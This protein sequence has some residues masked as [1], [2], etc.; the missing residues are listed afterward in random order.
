MPPQR[1]GA[2]EIM[3]ITSLSWYG[4]TA[5][6]CAAEVEG[7]IMNITSLSWCFGRGKNCRG[8]TEAEAALRETVVVSNAAVSD[9]PWR[10][11]RARSRSFARTRRLLTVLRG[12]PSSRATS[13]TVLPSTQHRMMHSR[14]T[15]GRR[16]SS[17]SS[18]GLRS[19]QADSVSAPVSTASGVAARRSLRSRLADSVRARRAT[20]WATLK[21]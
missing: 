14:Y 11:R 8:G 17:S 1:D 5:V 3:N 13:S 2:G 18:T 7:E 12:Q 16:A 4:R 9:N 15:A 20:R 19:R 10:I 6:L 21:S